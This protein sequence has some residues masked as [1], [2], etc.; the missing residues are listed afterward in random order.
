MKV[1]KDYHEVVPSEEAPGVKMYVVAGP[2]DG[3]PNFVMRVFEIAPGA[4]TPFHSHPWEHEVYV[5]SGTG[6]AR[7]EQGDTQIGQGTAAYVEPGSNH[8]FSNTGKE[9]L[10]FVCVI[11]LPKK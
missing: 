3:V 11:P 6:T 8:C 7:S 9:T 2:N 10:R 4:S 1:Y 5:V